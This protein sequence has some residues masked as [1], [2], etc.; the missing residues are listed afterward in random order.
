[1]ETFQYECSYLTCPVTVAV[2]IASPILADE[3]VRQLVDPDLLRQRADEAIATHPERLE[4][5]GRRRL[6]RF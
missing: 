2:R 1:M 3:W 4:G 6:L 5:V